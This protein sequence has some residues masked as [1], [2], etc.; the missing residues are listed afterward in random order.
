MKPLN[1]PSYFKLPAAAS[2]PLQFYGTFGPSCCDEETFCTLLEAGMTGMR[3]NLSHGD[4]DRCGNWLAAFRAAQ[5]RCGVTAD[6]MIDL[7]GPELRIGKLPKP[8]A[9]FCDGRVRLAAA[10]AS[11]AIPVP[12]AVLDAL[13]P[14]QPLLLDDGRIELR[15]ISRIADSVCCRVIRGGRLESCKSLAL[16]GISLDLPLLTE[17]DRHNLTLARACGVTQVM[18]PFVQSGDDIQKLRKSLA[19]SRIEDLTIFAKI[20][21]RAG[22]DHLDRIIHETDW[23]VIARGDLGSALPLW[24][25]PAAQKAIAARCR[26]QNCPFMVVT[27][28]LDSMR[29]HPVPTR[30]EVSDV[31]NAVCDGA[32]ALMLTGET[33]AGDYPTEAMRYLVRTATAEPVTL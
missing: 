20:E 16:P 9:L 29:R 12:A 32:D 22:L 5:A 26:A 13:V 23:L 1:L 8:L 6:L 27:Q 30:A 2:V 7:H 3:L 31:Y 17:S 10:P 14:G 24:Q 18:M 4:L 19:E 33:A 25:L 21:N 28:M 11:D 15:A